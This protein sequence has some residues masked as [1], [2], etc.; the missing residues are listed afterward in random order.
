MTATA[1]Q[2]EAGEP[3]VAVW[4]VD[5]GRALMVPVPVAAAGMIAYARGTFGAGS[6]AAAVGESR[7][8]ALL[9]SHGL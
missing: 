8:L 7:A 9:A 1:V 3:M 5:R 4:D 2:A 6:P